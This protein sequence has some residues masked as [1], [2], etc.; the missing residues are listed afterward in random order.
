[1]KVVLLS[2]GSGTRLWPISNES[3]PKQFIPFFED[4]ESMLYS[5]YKNVKK[6]FSD[7]YIAT[8]RDYF[9]LIKTQISKNINFIEEPNKIGTFGAI[10]NIAVYFKCC[11]M[12]NDDELIAVIP[13]DHDVDSKF[14]K[15]LNETTSKIDEVANMCLIGIKPTSSSTKFGYIL[16]K[17]NKVEKFIEKPTME[18]A[19]QL[20]DNNSLWN[21]GILVF[22]LKYIIELSKKYLKYNTYDEFINM[23]NN[24]PK[25]SFDREVLEKEKNIAIIETNDSWNDLGTWDSLSAKIST[26]DQYNT[27]IINFEN[28]EIR[29]NGIRDA[30]IVNS[31]EGL[32]L[33]NKNNECFYWKDWG[34]YKVIKNY[35]EENNIKIKF[36]N[37]FSENNIS[38]QYHKYRNEN[39]FILKGNGS[40]IIDNK[41]FKVKAGDVLTIDKNKLHCIRANSD[42]QMIE[43]QHGQKNIENDIVKIETD[44][45]KILKI[46]REK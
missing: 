30:I 45:K 37:I 39:W 42:L 18:V 35:E 31:V 11:K 46:I 3:C 33:I 25:N 6:H 16:H 19:K 8:Q 26:P 24:L 5:T 12:L 27:N 9:D 1:M 17:N 28:K 20:I 32:A 10:L 23:Y 13:T 22:K 40:V 38:Y 14:Y 36:L 44:W 7:I 41:L 4:N 15:I 34:Y 43:I 21:S 29:N 2:G